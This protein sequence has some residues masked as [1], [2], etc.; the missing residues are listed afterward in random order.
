MEKIEWPEGKQ[1]AVFLSH[2]VDRVRKTYQF[3]T[4][5]IIE[6]RLYH[7]FSMFQKPNPY[8]CFEKIM[9]IEKKYDIRST[10]FFLKETKKLKI[11]NPSS[12]VLSLGHYDFNEPAVK[13][14]IKKLDEGGWEIGLH[15][16]YDS[17]N[18][19]DLMLKEKKE[20]E[21]VLGKPVIGIRQHYLNLEIPKTWEF[22]RAIGFDYDSTFGFKDKIGYREERFMPFR[23]FNDH[24][25][26]IPLIVMD[27]TLFSNY[28]DD[29]CRWDVVK[30]A[31]KFAEKKKGLI[32]FLWHQRVFNEKEFPGWSKLYEK[33]IKEC[34]EKNAWFATGK[35]VYD[36]I[37]NYGCD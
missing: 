2:D 37:M 1:F 17:Y 26:I 11:F 32:S 36:R 12:Y 24:F 20:L 30:E 7:L 35:E 14:I 9:D 25:L 8:W 34:Q 15:G 19:K 21:K 23:P 31:I 3:F 4:H 27:G 33:I 6:K 28:K 22:H 5:V 29:R 13:Q 18:N 10:F 16:S